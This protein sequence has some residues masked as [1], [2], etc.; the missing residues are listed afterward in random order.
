MQG[1]ESEV[2]EGGFGE[3][4]AQGSSA[5]S[6]FSLSSGLG[7][8]GLHLSSFLQLLQ[9]SLESPALDSGCFS[10]DPEK[11]LTAAGGEPPPAFRLCLDLTGYA[12]PPLHDFRSVGSCR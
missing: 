5:A 8:H 12:F 11:E 2:R 6:A 3:D 4:V 10:N 9:R 1:E 7:P